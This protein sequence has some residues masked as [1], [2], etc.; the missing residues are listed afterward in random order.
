MLLT[1]VLAAPPAFASD[2]TD[3]QAR[4][5][6]LKGQ[7]ALQTSALGQL[8]REL[9]RIEAK[10]AALGAS[11]ASLLEELAGLRTRLDQVAARW[12][13]LQSRVHDAARIAFERGSF[14]PAAVV[15]G[16]DSMGELADGLQYFDSISRSVNAS[17]SDLG[18]KTARLMAVKA[19]VDAL[20]ASS[21]AQELELRAQEGSLVSTLLD[22]QQELADLAAARD[23]AASLVARLGLPSDPELTG[24]GVSY[25]RWAEL[26][27]TRLG[28]PVC[29]DNLKVVV[30]WETAEGTA[31][32]QNPLATTHVMD[33]AT[34]FNHVGV[35]NYPS[36]VVG[37]DASIETL[38][39]PESYGYGP[40]IGSLAA[41]APAMTTAQA[42]N[43]SAW[44]RGCAGGMYVLN[45]VPLVQSDYER[46][47]G[48]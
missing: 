10:V 36:L 43:G 30:A 27:L 12:D 41:C 4:L 7:I 47:A 18:A 20:S 26:L 37:L 5:D 48:R 38:Y 40:I 15:L 13:V 9:D 28:V 31:A 35:K 45:V 1:V 32:A 6:A 44:C 34:D 33:G 22:Q 11:R 25:G 16:A 14:A 29:A 21:A 8:H 24:A 42:I 46:F 39:G 17:A 19:S 23:E 2:L 3:E